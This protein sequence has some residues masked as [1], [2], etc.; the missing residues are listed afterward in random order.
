LLNIVLVGQSLKSAFDSKA[1]YTVPKVSEDIPSS[2]HF[3]KDEPNVIYFVADMF[4]G[5]YMKKILENNPELKD[6]YSGF[7]WYPNT[8]SISSITCSSIPPML[9]GYSK[10]IID[11]NKDEEHTM[12]EKITDITE[13]FFNKIKSQGFNFSSTEMIYS[14]IDKNKF[15]TFLPRWH[16]DWNKWDG[17]LK[18]GISKEVAYTLL[19]ENAAL[20]S[21]PLFINPKIYNKGKWLHKIDSTN[22]NTNSAKR[23]NLVRLL[24]YISNA[25]SIKP[26]F[27]YFHT[28]ASHHPWDLIDEE[29]ILHSDVSPYENNEWMI[30]TFA[31]WIHWMKENDVYDNTKIVFV[32][33]HGIHWG[34][35]KGEIDKSIPVIENPDLNLNVDDRFN[36]GMYPVLLVKD[37]NKNGPI[38]EDWRFM[39][40]ADAYSIVFNEENPT[41]VDPPETRVLPSTMVYWVRKIADEKILPLKYSINATNSAFDLNKWEVVE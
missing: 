18:I 23:Y 3:S 21:S 31:K 37:Y 28:M 41:N 1:F 20:F 6:V 11:L 7:V 22:E 35:F 12:A 40:N 26:T 19:W 27:I 25:N 38:S 36:K 24:P 13:D 15:D 32:S 16:K 5:W 33:D 17:E 14:E 9:G 30:K 29:G 39:S 34:H 8:L 4:H 10:N 2:I